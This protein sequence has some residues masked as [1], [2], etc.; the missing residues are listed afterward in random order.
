MCIYMYSI[1]G[2]NRKATS[3]CMLCVCVPQY[4]HM[5]YN[6]VMWSIHM[7]QCAYSLGPF[8]NIAIAD[9]VFCITSTKVVPAASQSACGQNMG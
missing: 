2:P 3:W 1:V 4:I 9:Q 5:A 8:P 6:R 7:P